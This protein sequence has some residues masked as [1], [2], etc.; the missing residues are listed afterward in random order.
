MIRRPPRSTLFPYTTLFRSLM[1][2][3][4]ISLLVG[5]LLWPHG[6]RRELA[7]ALGSVYR[8]LVEYVGLGFDRVLG[9]VPAAEFEPRTAADAIR[10]DVVRARDR[11]DAAFD[12]FITETGD[13]SFDQKTA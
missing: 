4:A 1:V 3:A 8:G 11:A 9:F 6:A 2:G 10:K 12:T 13:R 5:L 7:R